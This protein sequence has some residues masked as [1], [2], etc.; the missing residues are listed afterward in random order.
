M[1][2]TPRL[3]AEFYHA[4]FADISLNQSGYIGLNPHPKQFMRTKPILLALC[5]FLTG[6][7]VQADPLQGRVEDTQPQGQAGKLKGS[8]TDDELENQLDQVEKQF[9]NTKMTG[10]Q[11]GVQDNSGPPLKGAADAQQPFNLAAANDPDGANQ[12]LQIDWDR[13]RNRLTQTIQSNLI[14]LINIHNDA[15]FVFDPR[16]QMMVSRYPVGIYA[17]YSCDVLPNQQIINAR[18][19]LSS[20]YPAYDQAVMQAMLQLQGNKILRYP[21][22]SRREI[23][24]QQASIRTSMDNQFQNFQ[25][26]DVER[27]EIQRR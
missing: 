14:N 12:E 10:L 23:V 22:G 5:L 6:Q 9:G 8:A 11:S 15:N 4:E 24:N 18:V 16:R 1:L 19:T 7:W 25:F 20:G 13:W 26:G 21:K 27:Q 2:I 3:L 17:Q